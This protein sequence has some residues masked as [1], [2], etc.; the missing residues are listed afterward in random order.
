MG[1]ISILQS[2]PDLFILISISL[3]FALCFHEFA[4]G[5]IA[6]RCGDDTAYNMGRLTLNPLKHLDPIGTLM[7]LFIGFGYAKPVP[8]NPYNLDNPRKDMIKVAA[9]GPVSNFLLSF[10]GIFVSVVIKLYFNVSNQ[11]LDLF[12]NYFCMINIYLGLFNLL[13]IY[14]LDGGQIFGNFISKYN[15]NI[16]RQL[17]QYGPKIL[18]GVIFFSIIT[19]IPIIGYLI[20]TPAQKILYLFQYVIVQFFLILNNLLPFINV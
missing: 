14:P 13:P 19:N 5:Y 3:I 1:L 15:P 9:A 6:F 10:I 11:N 4:H 16:F 20:H 17:N 8:V 7:I 18:F 12:F 2:N